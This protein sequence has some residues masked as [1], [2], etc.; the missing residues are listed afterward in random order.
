MKKYL[1]DTYISKTTCRLLRKKLDDDLKYNE[2]T[3]KYFNNITFTDDVRE[4]IYGLMNDIFFTP[5]CENPYC[6]NKVKFLDY[7]RGYRRFCCMKCSKN[8]D[9]IHDINLFGGVHKIRKTPSTIKTRYYKKVREI[10]RLTYQ[11]N[12]NIINSENHT[13]GKC[14]VN[15]A[16]QLDHII[17]VHYGFENNINPEII[18]GLDN[19]RV[20]PWRVNAVKNKYNI[21]EDWNKIINEYKPKLYR[22]D[23]NFKDFIKTYCLDKSGRINTKINYDWFVSRNVENQ[24]VDIINATSYLPEHELMPFRM[25]NIYFDLYKTKFIIPIVCKSSRM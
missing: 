3:I 17:S 13:L 11:I 25:F 22:S 20:I 10:T 21:D 6:D 24:A 9:R 23:M 15:G 7:S 19:L 4:K 2:I 12:E 14:G 5:K 18:G 1:K 8:P 16:Y